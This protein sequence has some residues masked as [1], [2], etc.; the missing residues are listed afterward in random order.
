[1]F[2]GLFPASQG[3]NLALTVSCVPYSLGSGPAAAGCD[4]SVYR[5]IF[6]IFGDASR[7]QSS[8]HGTHQTVKA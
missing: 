3:R 2:Q 5:A 7:P 4:R 6:L 1:M 8:E